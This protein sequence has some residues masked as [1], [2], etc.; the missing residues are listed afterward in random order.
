MILS[1]LDEISA[2]V[3][4]GLE[5]SMLLDVKLKLCPIVWGLFSVF[6]NFS[7]A[8][9]LHKIRKKSAQEGNK[10]VLTA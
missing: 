2:F 10:K 9:K 5:A 8:Q 4:A 7:L 6:N 3:F 1:I